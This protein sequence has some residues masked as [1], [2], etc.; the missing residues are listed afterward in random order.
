MHTW[1]KKNSTRGVNYIN[2]LTDSL[3]SYAFLGDIQNINQEIFSM[4][5]LIRTLNDSMGIL[6]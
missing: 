1:Y 5:Y 4:W 6:Q 3:V 2:Y